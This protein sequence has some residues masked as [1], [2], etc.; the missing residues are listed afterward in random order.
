M[1]RSFTGA[2]FG[3]ML[4]WLAYPQVNAGMKG[5]EKSMGEKLR[6]AGAIEDDELK[7]EA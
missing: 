4:V 3:L 6:K 5:T 7:R 1:L 2:L